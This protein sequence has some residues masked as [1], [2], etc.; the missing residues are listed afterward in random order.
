[1]RRWSMLSESAGTPSNFKPAVC[2]SFPFCTLGRAKNH[3]FSEILTMATITTAKRVLAVSKGL[4]TLSNAFNNAERSNYAIGAAF[5][6]STVAGVL[7]HRYALPWML[8]QNSTL[9]AVLEGGGSC[10]EEAEEFLE[11]SACL[12]PTSTSLVE[13]NPYVIRVVSTPQVDD[14]KVRRRIKKGCR[15]KFI[16]EIVAAVKLRLGTPKPTMANRRA[17]QRVAREEMQEYNLRKTVASSI[18][19]LIVEATFVPTKWE[20]SAAR[21][22]SCALAQARKVETNLLLELAGFN[23]A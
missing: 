20:V 1:M 13:Y 18:L 6:C 5:A 10:P 9:R 19:P 8:D 15:G 16:R 2:R 21:V 3:P 14:S 11:S 23:Q 17:V 4:V 12:P 22:G 7:V